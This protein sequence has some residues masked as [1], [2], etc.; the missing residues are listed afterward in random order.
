MSQYD[1]DATKYA[2]NL[3]EKSTCVPAD[4]FILFCQQVVF[5]TDAIKLGLLCFFLGIGFMLFINWLDKK[6][7]KK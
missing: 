1:I 4:Q 3:S 6:W 5:K 2:Y 7:V